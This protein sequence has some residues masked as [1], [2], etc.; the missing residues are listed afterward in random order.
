MKKVTIALALGLLLGSATTAIAATDTVQAALTKFKIVVNGQ[1]QQLKSSPVVINGSSYL[2]VREVAEL[3]GHDVSFDKG[4]ISLDAK[5]GDN[6]SETTT[7][8]WISLRELSDQIRDS[9]G[10]I[11]IGGNTSQM[12]IEIPG[13]SITIETPSLKDGE[14]KS[15]EIEGTT[16]QLT[17]KNVSG[18]TYLLLDELQ[19]LGII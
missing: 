8:E 16:Q 2:P 11:T 6:V 17:V 7:Q 1:E 5:D 15:Y 3:L 19:A 12:T 10:L 4:T 9:G 13:T 14:S 18:A